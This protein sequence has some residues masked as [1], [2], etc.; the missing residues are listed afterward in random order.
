MGEAEGETGDG[1]APSE[2]LGASSEWLGPVRII[3]A[4]FAGPGADCLMIMKLRTK[5]NEGAVLNL[6]GHFYYS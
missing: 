5:L 2:W 3:R 4:T 6:L 1:S